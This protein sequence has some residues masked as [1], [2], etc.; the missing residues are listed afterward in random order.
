VV[1]AGSEARLHGDTIKYESNEQRDNIG[2]W[3][4]P[5]DWA[6]WQ[7]TVMKP[8]KFDVTAEIAAPE[9]ASIELSVGDQKVPG[10]ITAT[11]D[12]GRFRRMKLA[13]LEIPATGKTTLAVH[14]VSDGW[15]PVNLKSVRLTPAH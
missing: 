1:L 8:G 10:K 9:A 6:D 3:T 12:Y 7:F 5:S 11:G 13:T 2:F 4:E 14:A 15:H